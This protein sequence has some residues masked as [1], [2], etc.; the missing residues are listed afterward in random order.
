MSQLVGRDSPFRIRYIENELSGKLSFFVPWIKKQI[1]LFILK[2][3]EIIDWLSVKNVLTAKTGYSVEKSQCRY[4]QFRELIETRKALNSDFLDELRKTGL[5]QKELGELLSVPQYMISRLL[6]GELSKGKMI[7][8]ETIWKENDP[9]RMPRIA[10][11]R[12][13]AK[14]EEHI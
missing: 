6:L 13:Y 11:S 5:S 14:S 4:F 7:E 12:T 8:L 2:Y 9:H 10:N 3:K 1:F